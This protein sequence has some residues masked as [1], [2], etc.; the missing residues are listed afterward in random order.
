MKPKTLSASSLSNWEECKGK[1]LA[2]NINF[3]P[4]LGKKEP[5]RMGSAVHYALE[6]FVGRVYLQDDDDW[7]DHPPLTWDNKKALFDLFDEGFKKEFGTADKQSE[8]YKDGLVMVKAWY[9]RTDLTGKEIIAVEKKHRIAILPGDVLLTYIFDRVERW[10]DED[11]RKILKVVDYKSQRANY[12]HD[13]LVRKLQARIYALCAAIE[14]KK[15]EPDEIWVEMDMLRF[16]PVGV[17][18]TREDNVNTWNYLQ[19]T[20]IDILNT[21]DDLEGVDLFVGPGCRYCPISFSCEALRKSVES[22]SIMGLTDIADIV[23]E[24]ERLV[25]ASKAMEVSIAILEEQIHRH[26]E[27]NGL[28]EF[29]AGGHPVKITSSGRRGVDVSLAADIIGPELMKN[30]AKLNIGDVDTI[31]KTGLVDE[32]K[33]AK[34]EKLIVKKYGNPGLKIEAVPPVKEG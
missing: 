17:M 18:F 7:K 3:T 26:A 8:W 9:K 23:S 29:R 22:G 4:E 30:Y 19:E 20:T 12:T 33:A 34:L 13:E 1:F 16:S 24:R 14:F 27:E 15:W 21:P 2:T 32:E 28:V 10:I 5:A 6:H 31:I 25:G 11:G